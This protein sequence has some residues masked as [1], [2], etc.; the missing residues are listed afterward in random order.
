MKRSYA[1]TPTTLLL[2]L[3]GKDEK[4]YY[5]HDPWHFGPNHRISLKKFQKQWTKRAVV[6]V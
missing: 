2:V 3:K 6:I 5:L 4:S 1:K